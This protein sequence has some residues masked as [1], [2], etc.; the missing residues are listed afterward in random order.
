MSD[1]PIEVRPAGPAD[2]PAVERVLA[3]SYGT[4]LSRDYPPDL[5]RAALPVMTRANPAL[6]SSGTYHVAVLSGA[7]V[8]CGGWTLATP[9]RP[10]VPPDPAH[11]HVRHFATD[12]AVLRHG[13]GRALLERCRAEATAAGVARLECWSTLTA[14]PFYEALGFRAVGPIDV[15]LPG[16]RFPGVRLILAL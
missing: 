12:P 15:E 2:A 10:D 3:A 4:L 5:L 1:A 13:V 16:V 7:V 8:G 11:G 9:G 14:R 6:L